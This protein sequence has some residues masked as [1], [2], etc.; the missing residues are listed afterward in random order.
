[1]SPNQS[2]SSGVDEPEVLPAVAS[3]GARLSF[4]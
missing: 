4:P 1:M 3:K 2:C